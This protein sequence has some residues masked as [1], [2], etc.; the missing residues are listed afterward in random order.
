MRIYWRLYR[1]AATAKAEQNTPFAKEPGKQSPQKVLS[2]DFLEKHDAYCLAA[3]GVQ[4]KKA[5]TFLRS[6]IMKWEEAL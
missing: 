3:F 4:K 5:F 2:R 1:G 6:H